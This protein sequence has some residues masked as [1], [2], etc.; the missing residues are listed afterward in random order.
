[1]MKDEEVAPIV[2]EIAGETQEY[3]NAFYNMMS[4]KFFNIDK[5]R[6]EIKKEFISRAGMWVAKK[7]Y[8]QWIILK[9]GIPM[10][11]LDVKG[12]DVVRS[13]FPKAFQKFMKQTL[14]E[15]LRGIDKDT[16]TGKI[17]EFK[18]SLPTIKVYDIAKSSSVKELSK[19]TPAKGNLFQFQK[20]TPAHVKAAWAYNQLLKHFNCGFKYSPM[21]NGDKMKWVYLK[22]N[23][24]GLDALAF[25]GADDPE[26]IVSLIKNYIDYDGIFE[27]DMQ[28]KLEDF[29]KALGWGTL[30]LKVTK[31]DKF[32][33]F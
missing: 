10:D 25:K 27:S 22:Q 4:K 5:H 6:F 24:L 18:Q 21:R 28:N 30:Q 11:K 16:M 12:L 29:Y 1:M 14:I 23:P 7:R 8:A 19:Y 31:S 13:S 3:V 32:F 26:E 17:I 15:I 2:N 33:S 20:G 9:N